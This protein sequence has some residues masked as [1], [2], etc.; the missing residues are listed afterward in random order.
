MQDSSDMSEL[1]ICILVLG[2]V[3]VIRAFMKESN[4]MALP[5]DH[6]RSIAVESVEKQS[7]SFHVILH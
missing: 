3:A 1:E 4:L 6:F 7:L 2:H 5:C